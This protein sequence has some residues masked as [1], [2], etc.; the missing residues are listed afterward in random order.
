MFLFL[1]EFVDYVYDNNGPAVGGVFRV[2]IGVAFVALYPYLL[3]KSP[4]VSYHAYFSMRAADTFID[5][6]LWAILLVG[7]L[8]TSFALYYRAYPEYYGALTGVWSG[9]VA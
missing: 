2:S 3:V 4:I 8:C 6:L 5:S 9:F 1:L 7:S